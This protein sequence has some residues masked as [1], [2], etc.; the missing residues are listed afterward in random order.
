MASMEAAAVFGM[1]GDSSLSTAA[2]WLE[3]PATTASSV[4]WRSLADAALPDLLDFG[5]GRRNFQRLASLPVLE[6][7]PLSGFSFRLE[8]HIL[9]RYQYDER[10]KLLADAGGHSR[11]RRLVLGRKRRGIH[12]TGVP[13]Q[14]DVRELGD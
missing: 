13:D 2:A 7:S 1:L 5:L 8:G 4:G 6:E 9:W 11:I 10:R 3:G 14:V 12:R